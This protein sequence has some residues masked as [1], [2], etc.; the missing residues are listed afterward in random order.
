VELLKSYWQIQ[1][2]IQVTS[3]TGNY[4]WGF[5]ALVTIRSSGSSGT[6]WADAIC[7]NRGV[8]SAAGILA[9][10]TNVDTTAN[11]T[12]ELTGV[13]SNSVTLSL[14]QAVIEKVA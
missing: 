2:L 8:G 5:E 14:R 10:S 9:Y 6:L 11:N 4:E 12:F 13:V 3:D 1:A 7:F